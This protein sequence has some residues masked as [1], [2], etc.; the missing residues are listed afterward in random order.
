MAEVGVDKFKG[1]LLGDEPKQRFAEIVEK[2]IAAVTE[3]DDLE[4]T[5][6]L[7]FGDFSAREYLWQA[8]LFRGRRQ[9][10]DGNERDTFTRDARSKFRN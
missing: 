5:V 3:L 7:S 8:N 4:K 9:Y 1:D 6:H 10:N 2:A